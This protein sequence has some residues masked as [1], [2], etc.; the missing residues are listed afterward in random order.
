MPTPQQVAATLKKIAKQIPTQ[1]REAEKSTLE[2]AHRVAVAY[3]SGPYKTAALR[4][5]GHP[6]S[7]RAPNPPGDPGII[8]RQ[9][10]RFAGSW[11]RSTGSWSGGSL[12]S[13]LSN[14]SP[15]A[16]YMRGTKFMIAR[17]ITVLVV[18]AIRPVR[19]SKLRAALR[20]ALQP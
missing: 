15:E 7:R 8:N 16:H 11:R 20:R 1:L 13:R 9:S 2:T 19:I 4:R 14:S 6:Y 17:P 3:S 12:V 5:M 10:G 18:K